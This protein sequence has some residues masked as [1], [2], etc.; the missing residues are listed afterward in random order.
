MS[1]YP[2][3]LARD[4]VCIVYKMG[5]CR[6]CYHT[7][8]KLV[9]SGDATWEQLAGYGMCVLEGKAFL[10]QFLRTKQQEKEHGK[11]ASVKG[12]KEEGRSNQAP[13]G[14]WEHNKEKPIANST[15][16]ILSQEDDQYAK[17]TEARNQVY[18]SNDWERYRWAAKEYYK[19]L[20]INEK[21]LIEARTCLSTTEEENSQDGIVYN[22]GLFIDKEGK[23]FSI[24]EAITSKEGSAETN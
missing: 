19:F 18:D 11:E 5:L 13:E 14:D 12:H 9:E 20:H 4:C 17:L 10:T 24:S 1:D 22:S 3:C 2:E 16:D 7:A 8:R 21:A 15:E 23:E 6:S